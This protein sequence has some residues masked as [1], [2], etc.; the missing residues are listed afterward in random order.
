MSRIG[1]SDSFAGG[2]LSAD[3]RYELASRAQNQQRL[4][5][6]KHLIVLG[7]LLVIISIIILVVAWQARAGAQT[8]NT[9]RAYQLTQIEALIAN[10]QTLE[11]SQTTETSQDQ[12]QPIPDILSKFKQYAR[13][14]K[15][16]T[17]LGLPNQPKSRMMGNARLM[18]Y[19]YAI[20]DPS[21]EHLLD[22]VKISTSQIPGLEVTDMMVK[23]G[24]QDWLLTITLSRY[25]RTQ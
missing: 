24:K 7:V 5:Y 18:T 1:T 21:L 10:I 22:W 8:S 20:R 2:R 13:Q 9:R 14:A 23:P 19:P 17:E 3:D 6:P 16:S 15:L 25:E 11:Q 4:N 12:F